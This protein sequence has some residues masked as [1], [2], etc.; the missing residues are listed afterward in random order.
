MLVNT[1]GANIE[2]LCDQYSP[3]SR[4]AIRIFIL[5]RYEL[6]AHLVVSAVELHDTVKYHEIKPA[7]SAKT[8]NGSLYDSIM[9]EIAE[10]CNRPPPCA[11]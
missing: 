11:R 9:H 4:V 5:K 7:I 1:T 10:A 8:V 2:Y 3:G 6:S